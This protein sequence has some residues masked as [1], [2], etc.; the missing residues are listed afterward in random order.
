MKKILTTLF[1]T[2][3][4]FSLTSVA[5]AAD[6]ITK[7]QNPLKVNSI[8]AIIFLAVDIAIYVGVSF[9]ILAIIFVGFKFVLAQ[10]NDTKLTDAKKWFFYI[11]IGLAI[12]ISSKVIVEIVKN[13]L[14]KSGVVNESLFSGSSGSNSITPGTNTGGSSDCPPAKSPT[15][16]A[17]T[18]NPPAPAPDPNQGQF[19]GGGGDYGGGGAGGSW[20]D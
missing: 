20:Q 14:V 17:S 16:P 8:Q 13:T 10:G 4:L 5:N 6:C 1:F 12:L 9:A 2:T 18:A 3:I 11:I 15:P 19:Q 7:L